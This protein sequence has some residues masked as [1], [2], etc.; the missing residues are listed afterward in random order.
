MKW[1]FFKLAFLYPRVYAFFCYYR[2]KERRKEI[3]GKFIFYLKERWDSKKRKE[4][5]RHIFE[6]RGSRKLVYYMIPLLDAQFIKKFVEVEGLHYLNRVL[7]EGRSVILIAG[8][9]GN[10]H[11]GFN[12]LRVMGY[13]VIGIKGKAPRPTKKSWHQ[14]FRHFDT[15]ENIIFIAAPFRFR[16]LRRIS[17]TLRSGKIILYYGDTKEGRKKEKVSFL[18]KE[19]EFPT[20]IIHFAYQTKAA[21][22]PFIHFYQQGKITLIF[23]EPI[24][25]N[26]EEGEREY[27]RIVEDFV[28]ILE[29][30]IL[31]Q[32][33]Q[34][35]GIYG[36]TVLSDYYF[37]YRKGG[38]SLPT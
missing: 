16:E 29:S 12:A 21:V 22:I 25:R 33:Q 9:F 26:W 19:I 4:V 32:P 37:S 15:V 30:Y 31:D 38:T 10:L 23:K 18:D 13:D 1:L 20:G 3:E 7:K 27:K 28:K 34:Y 35:M 6:L 5:I 14:K 8:H 24:D 36:P 11:L 17:E 2:K